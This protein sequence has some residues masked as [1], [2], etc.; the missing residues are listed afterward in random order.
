MTPGNTGEVTIGTTGNAGEV[1]VDAMTDEEENP[2]LKIIR[3]VHY[4][5]F[6]KSVKY[7]DG[8]KR[9]FGDI[10]TGLISDQSMEMY[11]RNLNQGVQEGICHK[12]DCFVDLNTC[13]YKDND[14]N[15]TK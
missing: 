1:T 9:Q 15:F 11:K 14:I 10:A 2:L 7:C 4:T 12:Y 13:L 6:E 5:L 3:Y 8:C